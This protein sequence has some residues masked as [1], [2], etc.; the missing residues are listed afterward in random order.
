MSR[1]RSRERVWGTFPQGSDL[2]CRDGYWKRLSPKRYS[3]PAGGKSAAI[4]T[5]IICNIGTCFSAN[6]FWWASRPQYPFVRTF[7]YIRVCRMHKER[8]RNMFWRK[9][10]CGQ[11]R[12][13]ESDFCSFFRIFGFLRF[14]FSFRRDELR[15]RSRHPLGV[16][17]RLDGSSG[18][19]LWT[20]F[21]GIYVEIVGG[22]FGVFYDF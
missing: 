7:I 14:S 6:D 12:S 18:S 2:A 15:D 5:N 3:S 20:D 17:E 10:W 19:V 21:L 8:S 22:H 11:G 13:H 1:K 9:I 16:F 4:M